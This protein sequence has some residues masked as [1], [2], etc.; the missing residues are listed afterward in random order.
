MYPNCKDVLKRIIVDGLQ[1]ASMANNR[2]IVKATALTA[3]LTVKAK[4]PLREVCGASV[5]Q[6]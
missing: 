4:R 6:R 1:S 2:K 3:C 5:A